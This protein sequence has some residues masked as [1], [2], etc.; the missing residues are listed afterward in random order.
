MVGKLIKHELYAIFR[1]LVILSAATVVFAAAARLLGAIGESSEELG[2]VG[3][4]AILMSMF[5]TFTVLALVAAA[6]GLGISSFYRSLY[7][8][9]GYMTFSLPAS[10]SKIVGAKLIAAIV[11]MAAASVVSGVSVVILFVG[12][13]DGDVGFAAEL[14]RELVSAYLGVWESDPLLFAE[15]IIQWVVGIPCSLLVIYAILSVGQLFT[16]HRKLYTFLLLFGVYMAG[17]VLSEFCYFPIIEAA[18]NV[19]VH[20]AAWLGIATVAAI[21]AA[22]WFLTVYILKRKV[23]LL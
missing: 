20:L 12:A 8:G 7:R 22:C 14:I 15:R 9:E 10:P 3:V 1:V 18:G 13:G 4:G 5:Y 19:S 6:W 2:A 23:N 21:D 11:G 17:A 16:A